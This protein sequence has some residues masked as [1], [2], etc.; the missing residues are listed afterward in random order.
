M[1]PPSITN[2]LQASLRQAI[3]EARKRRHEYL[4]LE[5]LLLALLDNP[6]V[7]E[8][9]GALSVDADA[10]R[11]KLEMFLDESLETLPPSV[12]HPPQETPGIQRVLQRAAV[13]ALS[14]EREEIDGPS[15]L[16]AFF[17]EPSCHAL[18]LLEEEG[19]TRLEVL[20]WVS[21]GA[22]PDGVGGVN[23]Q[24]EGELSLIHI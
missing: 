15:V 19:L 3:E 17:R 2:E 20:R 18:F 24:E 1:T 9:F 21:H 14:S 5:H 4:T 11:R 22:D 13:H 16:V 8:M 23:P 10:V 7:I 6:K 12:D